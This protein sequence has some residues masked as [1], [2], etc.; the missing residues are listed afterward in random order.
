MIN[1]AGIGTL[2]LYQTRYVIFESLFKRRLN[3]ATCLY[4][5]LTLSEATRLDSTNLMS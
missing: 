3:P 2:D 1:T 4:P 5:L